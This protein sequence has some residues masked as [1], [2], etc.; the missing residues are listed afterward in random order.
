M[1]TRYLEP[2]NT[3]HKPTIKKIQ[4]FLHSL[5]KLNNFYGI[6]KHKWMNFLKAKSKGTKE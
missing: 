6:G 5:T 2:P 1:G 4:Y 3:K